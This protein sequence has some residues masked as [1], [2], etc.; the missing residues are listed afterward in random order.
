MAGSDLEY[1]WNALEFAS[2]RFG[3]K[4][5]AYD[6]LRFRNA[7]E[8]IGLVIN[9]HRCEHLPTFYD[10]HLDEYDWQNRLAWRYS[11]ILINPQLMH[12]QSLGLELLSRIPDW[13]PRLVYEFCDRVREEVRLER[14]WF[15]NVLSVH[16]TN[17]YA[18]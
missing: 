12:F 15:Y 6:E 5:I 1:W 16:L 2:A 14:Y 9:N 17:R 8:S 4:A 13:T 18:R 7:I 10:Q 11:H 3:G